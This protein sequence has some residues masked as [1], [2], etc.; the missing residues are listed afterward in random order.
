MDERRKHAAHEV[1]DQEPDVTQPVFDVV[2]KN[3]QE[4]HVAKNMNHAAVKKHTGKEPIQI[5][6][7][8]FEKKAGD[9]AVI[10]N[11]AQRRAVRAEAQAVDEYGHVEEEQKPHHEGGTVPRVGVVKGEHAL[12]YQDTFINF[13]DVV[14]LVNFYGSRHEF[15]R[16]FWR[17][18]RNE[19]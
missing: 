5:G 3:P 9:E 8:R 7:G 17:G 11:K 14:A 4:K 6:D 19:G 18:E 2:A 15:V 13:G 16:S 12:V 1:K 10:V